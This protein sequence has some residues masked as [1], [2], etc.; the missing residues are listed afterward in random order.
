MILFHFI[1]RRYVFRV[2]VTIGSVPAFL[3]FDYCSFFMW[4]NM[5]TFD[6]FR[7]YRVIAS[8]SQME[9]VYISYDYYF[10]CLMLYVA[11]ALLS[12]M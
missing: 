12:S 9:F 5:Y 8:R 6:L 1:L 2:T 11:E 4:L 7:S 3:G 10:W